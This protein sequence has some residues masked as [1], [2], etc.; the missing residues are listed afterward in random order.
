MSKA[1]FLGILNKKLLLILAIILISSG[2]KATANSNYNIVLILTD[3]QRYD[4][5]GFLNPEI[6]TPNIDK[7]AKEGVFFRNAFVTTSLCSPSRASILTGQYA[8]THG[9]VDNLTREIKPETVFFPQL[10]RDSGYQTA[11][12]GKW[13][14]GRHTDDPQPGFDHWISFA[15]QGNYLPKEGSKINVNGTRVDQKGY[16]TDELTD[17]ALDWLGSVDTSRN[18]FLYLSHKA[19][20]DNFTPAERHRD[21][22]SDQEISLPKSA[23]N[24]PQ[25][26]AGKPMWVRNQRNSWHGVDFPY[27]SD[28]DVRNY[29]RNY[30]RALAAV[31]DS[32]G[33]IRKMLLKRGVAENTIILFMGDNGFMFGEHGLIDKR[34]AYEESMRIPLIVHGPGMLA[35]KVEVTDLVANIDIAPTIL[36]LTNIESTTKMHGLSFARQLK[37]EAPEN[38]RSELL[39]EYFWEWVFPH[40]PTTYAI[41]TDKFKFIQYHGVWDTSEL[42]D[43]ENDPR[44]MNNLINSSEH[45]TLVR[46]LREK[47]F[48][49]ITATD[50]TAHVPFTMQKGP[51]LHFR[52]IDGTVAAEFPENILRSGDEGD[53][54]SYKD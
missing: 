37:G 31:D 15:G 23:E 24:T 49:M 26:Y 7:L 16:I 54:H 41:R 19:V 14:M 40:T 3:D 33:S 28:L 35:E 9:I 32:I 17:Y 38:W 18:F 46:E 10:L 1:N 25:N 43:L 20:H 6:D 13:H 4:E 11:F 21:L 45:K 36:E 44:E 51:G 12:I 50:G 47:L 5:L 8:H 27:H 52:S 48:S 42:Y 34:N 30:H 2:F 29:K 39:Y 22:Y 53:I